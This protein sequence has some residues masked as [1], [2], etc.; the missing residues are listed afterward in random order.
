MGKRCD[1][2][3]CKKIKTAG[4]KITEPRQVIIHTLQQV[5]K[6]MTV[7]ELYIRIRKIDKTIGLATIYRTLDLIQKN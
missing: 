2:I 6:H 4:A 3:W 5:K 1:N 7:E